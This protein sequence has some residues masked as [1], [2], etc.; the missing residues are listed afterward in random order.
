MTPRFFILGIIFFISILPSMVF[1]QAESSSIGSAVTAE[2]IHFQDISNISTNGE[3]SVGSVAERHYISGNPSNMT[4][5]F[6]LQSIV[7]AI[8][9]SYSSSNSSLGIVT[10]TSTTTTTVT[11]NSESA[12]IGTD[13][14]SDILLFSSI[15]AMITLSSVAVFLIYRWLKNR[16]K[17]DRTPFSYPNF[18]KRP[19][20]PPP[21]SSNSEEE[22]QKELENLVG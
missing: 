11:A 12:D 10:T 8:F 2:V 1:A 5:S 16:K 17:N 19:P 14:G 6:S 7:E 15:V 22:L 18:P 20:Q 13:I 9:K 4:Q 3:F 21:K